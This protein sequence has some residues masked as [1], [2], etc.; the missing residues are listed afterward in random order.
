MKGS[1]TT[2][3][4]GDVEGRVVT[5]DAGDVEDSEITPFCQHAR[6]IVQSARV[7]SEFSTNV[8]GS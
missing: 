4:A 7:I 3:D 5:L 2:L 6:V 8:A 1:V